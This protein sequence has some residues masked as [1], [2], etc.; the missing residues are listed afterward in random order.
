MLSFIHIATVLEELMRPVFF[1]ALAIPLL[2]ARLSAA[3]VVVAAPMGDVDSVFL[4]DLKAS[5]EAVAQETA[6]PEVGSAELKASAAASATGVALEVVL[7]PADGSEE[8]RETRVASWASA[9][10]Q[11]RAMARSVVRAFADRVRSEEGPAAPPKKITTPPTPPSPIDLARTT[12]R[13]GIVLGFGLEIAGFL[14]FAV[15]LIIGLADEEHVDGALVGVC[16]SGGA[17]VFG[18]LVSM[19]SYTVRHAAHLQ[20]GLELR[21]YKPVLGWVLFAATAAL[22]GLSVGALAE[23]LSW[24]ARTVDNFGEAIEGGLAAGMVVMLAMGSLV[25]DVISLAAVRTLWRRD[26]RLSE[27]SPAPSVAVS[28]FVAPS[29]SRSNRPVTGLS[30]VVQ[31]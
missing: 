22:Y 23:Y 9:I 28:P 27:K 16:A 18:S 13:P 25:A 31:F 8:I 14:G 10:A 19:T 11:A 26:L 29:G 2:M 6:L 20:A 7:V 17:V 1:F 4:D 5:I 21:P 15:S 30:A 3:A 24:D 12:A